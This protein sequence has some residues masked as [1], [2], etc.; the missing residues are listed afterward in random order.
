M[1]FDKKDFRE[2]G[3]TYP[4]RSLGLRIGVVSLLIG[5][6]PVADLRR[7]QATEPKQDLLGCV[8]I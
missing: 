4:S 5:A 1:R 2:S 7:T 3:K 6:Q 8:R